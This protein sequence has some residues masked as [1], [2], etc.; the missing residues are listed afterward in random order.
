MTDGDLPDSVRRAYGLGPAAGPGDGSPPAPPPP[1]VPAWEPEPDPHPA[2]TDVFVATPAGRRRGNV[3]AVVSAVSYGVVFLVVL[4]VASGGHLDRVSPLLY[5]LAV[6]SVVA[7]LVAASMRWGK[8]SLSLSDRSV[9][10]R[11]GSYVIATPWANVRHVVSFGPRPSALGLALDRDAVTWEKER[12]AHPWRQR[13]Y[14][15]AR[16]IPIEPFIEGDADSR[17]MA[18]IWDAE[19]RLLG[20]APTDGRPRRQGWGVRLLAF[21]IGVLPFA[22]AAGVLISYPW[23]EAPSLA[24]LGSILTT[25]LLV[26]ALLAQD[27]WAWNETTA[28]RIVDWVGRVLTRPDDGE[29]RGDLP[30]V[31]IRLWGRFAVFLVIGIVLALT[32]GPSTS[33]LESANGPAHACFLEG[34]IV[35]G[36]VLADGTMVGDRTDQPTTCWFREPMTAETSFRCRE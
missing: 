17:V 30:A 33:A 10:Y 34:E 2:W 11:C 19:P 7:Q 26:A 21:A 28:E 3:Q 27:M 5:G 15:Y 12:R 32:S 29:R 8:E 31:V 1:F 35:V 23:G 16:T 13:P 9:E 4:F 36:C 25:V 6:V 14:R 18:A 24:A 22:L 20:P